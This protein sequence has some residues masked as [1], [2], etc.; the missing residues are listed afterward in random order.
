MSSQEEQKS[1][2]SLS[3]SKEINEDN[4]ISK[5]QIKNKEILIELL[6][7]TFE[8]SLLRLENRGK[9]QII[10][11]ENSSS[12]YTSFDNII[13]DLVEKAEENLKK[14]I[15][16][17][18]ISK[19]KKDKE[20]E[21]LKTESRISRQNN[22]RRNNLERY[23]TVSKFS[24]SNTPSNKLMPHNS[25]NLQPKQMNKTPLK[26][27]LTK[28]MF[29][30][31]KTTNK[32]TN[33]HTQKTFEINKPNDASFISNKTPMQSRNN[34]KTLKK[35]NPNSNT[36]YITVNRNLEV[37]KSFIKSKSIDK[38]K[39]QET[40]KI[41]NKKNDKTKK[42]KST[43]SSTSTSAL[44]HVKN[45]DMKKLL[46]KEETKRNEKKERIDTKN[47]NTEKTE[48]DNNND[49]NNEDNLKEN[50]NKVE[51]KNEETKKL[52]DNKS[53]EENEKLK[54]INDE[55]NN[56]EEQNKKEE[57]EKKKKEEEEKKKKEE[58][59][60]KKKEEDEKNDN[61]T[62]NN[63]IEKENNSIKNEEIK[64]ENNLDNSNDSNKFK[65]ENLNELGNSK[66]SLEDEKDNSPKSD[67]V[68]NNYNGPVLFKGE[69]VCE[70]LIE[71]IENKVKKKKK[72]DDEFLSSSD[73]NEDI[74]NNENIN[75]EEIIKSETENKENENNNNNEIK[76]VNEDG[77][78]EIPQSP[79]LG[80]EI[81]SLDKY[82]EEDWFENILS[83]L[84][85]KDKINLFSTKKIFKNFLIEQL[86]NYKEKIEKMN[87]L[88][89]ID[90]INEQINE[91]ETKSKKEIEKPI[92]F[93]MS[94][95][96]LKAIDCLNKVDYLKIFKKNS[97]SDKE[98]EIILIYRILFNLLN[99]K[100]IV[101]IIDD[102]IFWKKV[103]EFFL[104]KEKIGNYLIDNSKNFNFDIHNIIK[105]EQ[106]LN[107]KKNKIQPGY[108][109]KI[110][111]TTSLITL[112]I[113]DALEF[114]CIIYHANKSCP[115]ILYKKLKYIQNIE[116]GL[117]RFI[118][119]ISPYEEEK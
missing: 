110:C 34:T 89:N 117:D 94:K 92:E 50:I 24:S 74:P 77:I 113:K 64:N 22:K 116:T 3:K 70:P 82:I 106:L 102:K 17:E 21:P 26:K 88:E 4:S 62:N 118:T 33:Y 84:S 86:F 5:S 16:E 8:D 44:T 51:I 79:F 87:S 45:V 93:K 41:K 111:G 2:N 35:I 80:K 37:K 107:N 19:E 60:K 76:R 7:N 9:E 66:V 85:L 55:N 73:E 96:S 71:P 47:N 72:N 40:N 25:K 18:T 98:N 58:E 56:N 119:L 6:K 81:Q 1:E 95:A 61:N 29:N 13:K 63:D 28:K 15:E 31:P 32:L 30:V 10:S 52:E 59:E 23:K 109:S 42:I 39:I 27:A 14:K 46:K 38:K 65:N 12:V 20:K 100:E 90:K 114:G 78:Q 69:K 97:L 11:L 43:L 75:N 48:D 91:L 103:C 105:I 67:D 49:D 57:E 101:N 68:N 83:Y 115:A 53:N 99:D 104:K 36:P 108:Y 54:K 112:M